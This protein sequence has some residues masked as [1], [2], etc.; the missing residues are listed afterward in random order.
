MGYSCK[1]RSARWRG[2]GQSAGERLQI[3]ICLFLRW[4]AE[5]L[6]DQSLQTRSDFVGMH[7]SSTSTTPFS[8]KDILNLEHNKFANKFL[9]A[10]Q[11]T[12]VRYQ[13]VHGAPRDRGHCHLQPEPFVSGMPE[14]LDDHICATEEE[15]NEHGENL[16]HNPSVTHLR[17]Q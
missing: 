1:V 3:Y 11:D 15:I 2:V 6:T 13:H 12:P 16:C 17:R 9:M 14:K 4:A 5:A 7:P 8:V 10:D